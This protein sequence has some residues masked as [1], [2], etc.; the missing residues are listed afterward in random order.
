MKNKSIVHIIPAEKFTN[1]FIEFARKELTEYYHIFY[2][3]RDFASYG[4]EN[5]ENCGVKIICSR[6][7]NMKNM[8]KYLVE[9][10]IIVIHSLSVEASCL[11]ISNLRLLKKSAVVIWGGEIYAHKVIPNSYVRRMKWLLKEELK[12]RCFSKV[13]LL[14]TF[15]SNDYLLAQQYYNATGKQLDILYPSTVDISLLDKY[16][17]EK[18]EN[19]EVFIMVGNSATRTNNHIDALNKLSAYKNNRIKIIVPLSYGDR[20]YAEEVI[21]R[22]KE[23]FGN[24][25]IPITDFYAPDDYA[26]LLSTIDVAV[27]Y[28]DRQQATGNIEILSYLGAKMYLRTDTTMWTF[29]HDSQKCVFFSAF[30]IGEVS[31]ED[32]IQYNREDYLTNKEYFLRIWDNN[33]L[34]KLWENV[35]SF[36]ER[37]AESAK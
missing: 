10:D 35:I 4:F 14:L 18:K 15:A 32:F 20:C 3:Y 29:Y 24:K 11:F 33:Y 12:K 5:S 23:I 34:K 26:K 9:T 19:S 6:K 2:I 27:F 21:A 22:G 13:P 17:R 25:F 8:K 30:D 7:L 28:N 1:P 31:F 37:N 16:I 36:L